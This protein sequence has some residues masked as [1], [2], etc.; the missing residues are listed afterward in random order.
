LYA[1]IFA[2]DAGLASK[3][4][5]PL[6]YQAACTTARA[7]AGKDTDALKLSEMERTRL[8]RQ[9]Y[10]W[11]HASLE[12]LVKQSSGDDVEGSVDA[13]ER[14]PQWQTNPDLAGVRDPAE[15]AKLPA[16]ERQQWQSLWSE[17]QDLSQR[18][19]KSFTETRHTGSLTSKE[20]SK[21]HAVALVADRAY[22]IDMESRVFDTF[23]TLKDRKDTKLAENDDITPENLNSRIIY[24]PRATGVYQLLATAFQQTGTGPYVLRIREFAE[25]K[26]PK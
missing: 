17:V 15:L 9:A 6:R 10:D 20:K 25:P 21:V 18:V 19:A 5:P 22:V 4:E 26:G 12:Q 24:T 2:A 23:L 7:T 3:R 16:E 13:A 11:L 8:R 14:L 1:E